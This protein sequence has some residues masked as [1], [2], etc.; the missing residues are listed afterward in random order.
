MTLPICKGKAEAADSILGS[1]VPS[2]KVET[3]SSL[4]ER[5]MDIE[6]PHFGLLKSMNTLLIIRRTP[7]APPYGR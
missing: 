6:G 3:L 1:H 5:K 7:S 2:S 4:K